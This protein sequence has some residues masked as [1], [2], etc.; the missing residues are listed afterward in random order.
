[1]RAQEAEELDALAQAPLHHVPAREHLAQDLPDLARPEVE[2][3]IEELDVAED[4]FLRQVRITDGGKLHTF[5]VDEVDR[6][7]LAQ[8]AILDRL[9]IQ[10][11]AGIGR[12]E[13]DLNGARIDLLGE[14][15]G[16]RNGLASLARQPEDEG[17]VDQDAELVTIL[18]EAARDVGTQT[19]LDVVQNLII[20]G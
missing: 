2:A 1:M 16:L 11:R 7:I 17:A 6:I 19:L 8:P 15:D 20:A 18:G 5:V 9:P 13:R 12:G 10:A 3:L 14:A 4:L